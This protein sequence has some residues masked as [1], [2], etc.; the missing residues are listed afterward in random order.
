MQPDELSIG[1]LKEQLDTPILLIDLDIMESNIARMAEYFRGVD[2]DLR[3]HTKTHKTPILAHKQI[4]AGAIGVTC[5]KLGEAEV[6][7]AAGIKD[8][9]IA[10]EI[11]PHQ[12]IARLVNLTKHADMMVA[13]DDTRNIENLS[14]AAQS[15]GVNLRVLVDVDVGMGRCGVPPGEPALQL[16]QEVEKSKNLVFAGI[17][18]YEGHTVAI[19]DFAERKSAAEKAM[20]QLVGTKE[21]IEQNGL[22]VGIVSGGGTGTYNIT[23]QFPGMTEIQAGSYILMDTKYRGVL[24]DFGCALSVLVTVISRP[25]KNTAITDAGMKTMTPEFGMAEVKDVDGAELIKLS[26][27]HGILSLKGS[28]TDLKPGDRLELIPSHGCTTI[29]LHDKFYGIRDGILES[30]WDIAARGKLR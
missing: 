14:Q 18:G 21:L 30:V 17:M 9:L 24:S 11:V 8:V 22:E 26:E 6:M 13:V 12:K 2:A 16:A 10:N 23:G 20:T 28:A 7:V 3:P 25:N 4:E 19:A 29:N 1:S 5:A 27:E 15:K